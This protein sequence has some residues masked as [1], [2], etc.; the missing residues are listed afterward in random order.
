MMGVNLLRAATDRTDS[1]IRGAILRNSALSELMF[2]V[3]P[4]WVA[5]RTFHTWLDPCVGG[6]KEIRE[7]V[8][9]LRT[10]KKKMLCDGLGFFCFFLQQ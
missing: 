2:V 6:N 3:P 1:V 9:Y 10:I 7:H 4:L 5:Q 8:I